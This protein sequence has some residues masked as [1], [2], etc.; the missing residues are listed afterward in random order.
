MSLDKGIDSGKEHRKKYYDSRRFD[1]TCRN[2]GSCDHCKHNRLH[3]FKKGQIDSDEELE[4]YKK[5]KLNSDD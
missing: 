4:E 3:K 2:H 5:G 1:S